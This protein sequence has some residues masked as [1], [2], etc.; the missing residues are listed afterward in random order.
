MHTRIA[1]KYL[2]SSC[3]L[4]QLEKCCYFILRNLLLVFFN[5]N[6]PIPIIYQTPEVSIYFD[7][8]IKMFPK[9]FDQIYLSQQRIVFQSFGWR[10][11]FRRSLQA[12]ALDFVETFSQKFVSEIFVFDVLV[13]AHEVDGRRVSVTHV[14]IVVA[15]VVLDV[16][17]LV[18]KC[19]EKENISEYFRLIHIF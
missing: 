15:D 9:G 12:F 13:V 17:F 16:G 10:Q 19:F 3:T 5:F 6:D 8:Q 7:L 11:V 14:V 4:W 1:R 18:L 2:R